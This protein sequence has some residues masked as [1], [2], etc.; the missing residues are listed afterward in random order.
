MP[1]LFGESTAVFSECR[2]YRYFLSRIW[3]KSKPIL[4]FI[5][6]NPSTGNENKDDRTIGRVKQ[7]AYHWGYGGVYMMNLFAWVSKK[8][9]ALKT[10][11]DPVGDND[12]MLKKI[13]SLA[14]DVLFAWGT[15]KETKGRDM[16]VIEMFPDAICL[17]KNAD[18]SPMHP[19][20]IPA[21][22]KPEKFKPALPVAG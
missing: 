16:V 19:L 7:F 11:S 17:G 9:S 15:F 13:G 10:C 2:R 12:A 21:D 20:Y 8:P 5:G 22:R 6:L 1:D 3:D 4:L 14:K 18:G